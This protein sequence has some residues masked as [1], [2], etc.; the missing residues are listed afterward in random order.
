MENNPLDKF[1]HANLGAMYSEWH[2]YDLAAPELEKAAV[3]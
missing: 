2:K 3:T 1:A